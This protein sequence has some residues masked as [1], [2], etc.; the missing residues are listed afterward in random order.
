MFSKFVSG[1]Q[2]SCVLSVQL[3]NGNFVDYCIHKDGVSPSRRL[4]R[5][6]DSE[7]IQLND[8]R[9]DDD[10]EPPK[11]RIKH[12]EMTKVYRFDTA[13]IPAYA[14]LC[15]DDITPFHM[16]LYHLYCY[17]DVCTES[18]TGDCKH[19]RYCIVDA[20]AEE[21]ATI[22]P[23]CRDQYNSVRLI[24]LVELLKFFYCPEIIT[25]HIINILLHESVFCESSYILFK[26]LHP[27]HNNS[28]L[29][30]N[31]FMDH[32][33]QHIELLESCC[34]ALLDDNELA[35]IPHT[36]LLKSDLKTYGVVH[37]LPL[38]NNYD[39][40]HFLDN[41]ICNFTI[42][43]SPLLF[44]VD[45][46]VKYDCPTHCHCVH[47]TEARLS[48]RSI[49][50]T[51]TFDFAFLRD[52]RYIDNVIYDLQH[53]ETIF[54]QSRDIYLEISWKINRCEQCIFIIT[55][56][57][58]DFMSAR[59][60][61]DLHAGVMNVFRQSMIDASVN[62]SHNE[63]DDDDVLY[64]N[65]FHVTNE[66]TTPISGQMK[67]I[68]DIRKTHR[69][70]YTMTWAFSMQSL[71]SSVE[72]GYWQEYNVGVYDTNAPPRM[73]ILRGS[74]QFYNPKISAGI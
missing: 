38:P 47:L 58:T 40:A 23:S 16:F 30:R 3:R 29:S 24:V 11:K 31:V 25:Y 42:D 44:Y 43:R 56:T 5:A 9:L 48:A 50:K 46:K 12:G 74:V 70:I 59:P 52:L 67:K 4:Q 71:R 41:F 7:I 32:V 55:F 73:F 34:A 10:G 54:L 17:N 15:P 8:A 49:E 26:Y 66:D 60:K 13:W 37:Q 53:T 63:N 33:H 69:H 68:R 21:H 36:N 39:H 65:S 57:S 35:L 19:Y 72:D 61:I 18:W 14:E 45:Q 51:Y 1:S 2:A 64:S 6:L 28:I 20:V 27:V 62:S 22:I